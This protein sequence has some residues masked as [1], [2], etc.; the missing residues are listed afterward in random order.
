MAELIR[1]W[2]ISC[3]QCIRESKIS[4]S[5]TQFPLQSPNEHIT[6]PESAMQNDL[7]P[8]LPPSGDYGSFVTAMHVFVH[9]LFA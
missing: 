4:R 9:F 7:V 8:E 6:E 3:K 2:V 5:F 1:E